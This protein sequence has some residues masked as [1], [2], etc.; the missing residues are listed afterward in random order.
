MHMLEPRRS[1]VPLGDIPGFAKLA[2]LF[3]VSSLC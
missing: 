1:L 3:A 2:S